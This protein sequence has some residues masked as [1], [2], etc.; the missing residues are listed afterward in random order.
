MASV[1]SGS[2]VVG[3]PSISRCSFRSHLASLEASKQAMCSASVVD[4]ATKSCFRDRH[5]MAPLFEINRYPPC[6]LR[7]VLSFIQSESM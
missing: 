6:D 3:M 7:F 4:V 1:P 5:E 2:L